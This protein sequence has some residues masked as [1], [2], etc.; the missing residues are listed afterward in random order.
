M[1][2]HQVD[3]HSPQTGI[4]VLWWRSVG[5]SHT[6]FVMESLVDELAHAA[7]Q[8]PLDYRRKLLKDE[9]PPAE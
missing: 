4:K 6:A 9:Q 1:A 3:L 5:H 7:G 2:N 8:D